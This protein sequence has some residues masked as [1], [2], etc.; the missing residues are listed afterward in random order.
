MD[1]CSYPDLK[2]ER[3]F[4]IEGNLSIPFSCLSLVSGVDKLGYTFREVII[5]FIQLGYKL[6]ILNQG[7]LLFKL[8]F[9]SFY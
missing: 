9:N 8:R 7:L 4:A 5:L 2:Y 3:I 6:Y 1:I